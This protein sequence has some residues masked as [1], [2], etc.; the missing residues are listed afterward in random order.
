MTDGQFFTFF[1]FIPTL[2]VTTMYALQASRRK[3]E[4]AIVSR[5]WDNYMRALKELP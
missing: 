3:R 2:L 5:R 1:V 4:E